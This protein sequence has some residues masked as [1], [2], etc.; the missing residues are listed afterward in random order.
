MND[1]VKA[2]SRNIEAIYPLAPMQQGLLF[3]SLLNPG[4]GMYLLQYRH[5]MVLPDLDLEAFRQAWAQVIERH[6]LLRTSFVWKQQKRPM[7]VVHKQVELPLTFEDWSH[8]HSDTQQQRLDRLLAEERAE[9]LDFTKAPLM[10]IRL[11]KLAPDT[12][13]FVRSYHHILM[14][15]WCFSIIMVDFFKNYR[16]ASQ[17]QRL[18][19]PKPRPY[20]DFV[21]WLESQN[22]EDHRQFW[23][24][25]LAGFDTPNEFGFGYAG[26]VTEGR[27]AGRGLRA[28][29]QRRTDPQ[30]ATGRRAAW[31]HPE[32]SGAGRLDLAHEP[33]QRRSRPGGRHHRGR[34]SCSSTA[35]RCVG[36]AIL[37]IASAPGCA[38]CR[39][40][41]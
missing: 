28:A 32:H 2:L 29:A 12:Y 1:K 31:H 35:C 20:R 13:Q 24:Q 18:E 33:L 36:S 37:R 40:K 21:R 25:R 30:P 11:Y 3:H 5:V 26:R 14:D 41:A 15:A 8:L 10:R 9:G 17:G 38:D 39:T 27:R 4:K 22:S 6:E 7:Q 19:Q 34:A 16:A 23:Q